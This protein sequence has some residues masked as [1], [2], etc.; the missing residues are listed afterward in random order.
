MLRKR[1]RHA[2]PRAS[3]S[4]TRWAAGTACRRPTAPRASTTVSHAHP[5]HP[6]R[7]P[8]R[9]PNPQPHTHTHAR[10]QASTRTRTRAHTH[11][12]AGAGAHTCK[13]M[14]TH[15]H[16]HAHTPCTCFPKSLP[17]TVPD[18]GPPLTTQFPAARECA[19]PGCS[20]ARCLPE[21]VRGRTGSAW[22]RAGEAFRSAWRAC[23]D[24]R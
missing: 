15:T 20:H 17:Q 6:A 2:S 24:T 1:R 11:T 5:T 16:T 23:V 3:R 13:H 22:D 10:K 8:S 7:A 19:D 9:P 4:G 14:T 12:H 18:D 21:C